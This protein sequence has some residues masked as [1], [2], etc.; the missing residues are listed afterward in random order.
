LLRLYGGELY[1]DFTT[2]SETQ[3]A[4]MQRT[5]VGAIKLELD[6]LHNLQVLVYEPVNDSPKITFVTARQDAARLPID[7]TEFERRRNLHLEKMQ[8]MINYTSQNHRC[9]MQLIQ[10]YFNEITD[11][12]CGRC[13][14]CIDKHKK[15][16]T[17]LIKDYEQQINYLL[18]QK[19]MTVDELEL[20]VDPAE[21]DV[22]IEVI[23]EL[24]DSEEVY[25]DEVWVLHKR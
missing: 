11:A 3:I 12:T 6:Q 16:N 8:A 22:F 10:E 19:P 13:D 25:Y 7:S 5:T 24:V 9:R 1:T 17:A 18:A 2:I 23:R 4:Q 20:A 21:K 14:V 15:E